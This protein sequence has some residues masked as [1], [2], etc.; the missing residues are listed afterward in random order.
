MGYSVVGKAVFAARHCAAK[1]PGYLRRSLVSRLRQA[2]NACPKSTPLKGGPGPTLVL[3]WV[4]SGGCYPGPPAKPFSRVM[5]DTQLN[6]T[7]VVHVWM[8]L[9]TIP[10][11]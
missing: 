7:F 5:G 4:V 10:V 8:P 6:D 11:I 2:Q 3:R 1:W 9:G